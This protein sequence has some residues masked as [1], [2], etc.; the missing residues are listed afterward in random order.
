[1][2]FP[3]YFA[4][5]ESSFNDADFIIFGVPFDKTSS[6]RIGANKA[7]DEIRKASWNYETFNLFTDNDLRDVKFHDYGNLDVKNDNVVEMIGKVK[8]FTSEILSKN[9]FPIAIGGE[10]SITPGIIQAFPKDIAVLSLDAHMDFRKQYENQEYNHACV[11]NRISD[12]I[13]I[14][15][16]ALLGIRSAEKEEYENAKKKE[17]FYIDFFKIKDFGLKKT[18]EI[19]KNFLQNKKIYLTLDIDVLDIAYAPGTSTPEPFGLTSFEVLKII[20]FFSSQ[21]VGF[22]V[23]EVCP[24]YDNGQTAFLAAKYIRYVIDFVYFK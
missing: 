3:K 15:N 5:A 14:K 10:H 11:I 21:L 2:N 4:D 22:D 13:E 7:P 6:F 8:K 1:M 16:I 17:L 20:K 18:L 12:H 23:V 24:N 9:K 19:T